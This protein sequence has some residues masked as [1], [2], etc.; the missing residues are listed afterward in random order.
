[1]ISTVLAIVQ[2]SAI[3]EMSITMQ[4]IIVSTLQ[5][6]TEIGHVD[7]LDKR[8]D[9]IGSFPSLFTLGMSFV[10]MT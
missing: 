6:V 4:G 10:S 8:R 5:Y 1:M 2:V 3:S 9:I 7:G